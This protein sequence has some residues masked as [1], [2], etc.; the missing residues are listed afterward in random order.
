MGKKQPSTPP[1]EDPTTKALKYIKVVKKPPSAYQLFI[2]SE[3][4]N[5]KTNDNYKDLK[6]QTERLKKAAEEWKKL[7]TSKKDAF[8]EKA[9]PLNEIY[10]KEISEG[11]ITKSVRNKLFNQFKI[12]A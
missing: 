2:K 1:K 3:L 5:Y 11:A 12:V 8:Q 4:E 7:E 10:R 6:T 9:K